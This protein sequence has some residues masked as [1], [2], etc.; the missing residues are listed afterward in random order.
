MSVLIKG[1]KMPK[2]CFGTSYDSERDERH[3]H[4]E[5]CPCLDSLMIDTDTGQRYGWCNI[6]S[7]NGDEKPT[8]LLENDERPEWCPL[9]E[10]PTPHGR[11]IDEQAVRDIINSGLAVMTKLGVAV[12]ADYLW[13]AI[14]NALETAPTV[15]EA[16]EEAAQTVIRDMCDNE[17][18]NIDKITEAHEKLGYERGWRDGYAE[19]ITDTEKRR[20]SNAQMA[21]DK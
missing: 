14:N 21:T 5:D 12:D 2:R 4:C 18:I 8:R 15:I 10:V 11:L 13:E 20:N 3:E 1:M 7:V 6:E 16:E 17:S 19:A 9:I